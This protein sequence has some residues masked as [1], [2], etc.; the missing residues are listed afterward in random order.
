VWT[1]ILGLLS[2]GIFALYYYNP[3]QAEEEQNT[4]SS[5]S[6]SPIEMDTAEDQ[7]IEELWQNKEYV[8]INNVC[9]QHLSEHPLDAKYL[10]VNGFAY[11]YRGNSLYSLEDQI[12]LYDQA[13]V[14]LR[15]AL[16]APDPP[17]KGEIHYVLGKTYYHKGRFYVDQAVK[18]LKAS[19]EAG[20]ESIDTYRYLGLAY[21][22]LGDYQRSVEHFLQALER[23]PEPLLYMTIGQIYHKLENYDRAL[24]FLLRAVHST[25]EKTVE[26]KSRF[27]LGNIYIENEEYE[28]AQAQYEKILSIDPESADAH[29]YLG[30]IYDRM[31]DRVKARAEWRKALQIDPSHYGALLKLY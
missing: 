29:Y 11:F 9:E 28:K 27:V 25:E 13:V 17:M 24:D 18:H 8:R 7:S 19:I 12:P 20:Y 14:N 16:I 1:L 31:D 2:S 23:D 6:E 3:F 15:K 5:E 10:A 22:E 26:L 21:N 30:D 4:E